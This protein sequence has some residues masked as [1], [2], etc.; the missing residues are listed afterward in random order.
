MDTLLIIAG[1][2][3]III[4]LF[5]FIPEIKKAK[6]TKEKWMAFSGFVLDPFTGL[7]GLFYLGLILILFGLLRAF[8]LI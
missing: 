8:D 6:T 4:S 1:I 3:C 2:I 7:T 5:I